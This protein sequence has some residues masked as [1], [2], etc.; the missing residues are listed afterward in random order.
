MSEK[1]NNLFNGAI[2]NMTVHTGSDV[3]IKKNSNFIEE[4][5]RVTIS[6]NDKYEIIEKYSGKKK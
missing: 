5:M 3:N 4:L 1:A 6:K 2:N